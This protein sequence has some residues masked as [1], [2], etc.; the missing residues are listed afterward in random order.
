MTEEQFDALIQSLQKYA[1]QNPTNYKFRVALLAALGYGYIFFVFVLLCGIFW[2]ATK[3]LVFSIIIA[4]GMARSLSLS[5]PKPKG[6]EISRSELPALFALID[7]LTTALQAPQFHHIILDNQLNAAVL[8]VPRFGFLGWYRNYLFL[9]LPLMQSLS[10]AEFRAVVAHELG[11]LSGNHSRFVGWIYRLRNIWY[12]FGEGLQANGQGGS[13]LFGGFFK[14]YAPFFRAYSF[15]LARAHEY[16]ADRCAA[17]LAGTHNAAQ[18]LINL[19]IKSD[20]LRKYFWQNIFKKAIDRSSPPEATITN[21]VQQLR[22]EVSSED[23]AV[24]LDLALAEKTNNEDTHPCLFDRLSAFGYLPN[25]YQLPLPASVEKTAA[26]HFLGEALPNYIDRLDTEWQ[27]EISPIWKQLHEK[28]QLRS[29][30]LQN[31]ENLAQT[32]SLTIEQQRKRA[33]LTA[34]FKGNT[35]AIPLYREVLAQQPQHSIANFELG[36]LLI[37]EKDP[38]GIRHIEIA[39][40]QDPELLIPGSRLIFGFLKR[41]GKNEEAKIYL[42]KIEQNYYTWRQA[43]TE[44]KEVSYRDKFAHHNLP[45]TEAT[46]LA[47]QLATYPQIKEA[48]LVQKVV[49]HLPENPFYVLG[50]IRRYVSVK[51]ADY[52]SDTELID[53]VQNQLNFSGDVFAIVLNEYNRKLAQVL[54]K[55][56]GASIYR[57]SI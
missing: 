56:K 48:F 39:I 29:Q 16:E 31:L 9:G 17:E 4:V 34:E 45:D 40:A 11:H 28:A 41:Q 22:N 2:I 26:A 8:Q 47:Q 25:G 20:Y 1:R 43:A 23:A 14:W 19:D 53:L 21:L 27:N 55:I 36:H 10:P 44:R 49:T 38:V 12:Q 24:W 15:V 37:E 50:I 3:T 7:E 54:G 35:A 32:Q 13:I 52:K 33:Q 5:F 6:V 46:Q 51:V 42:E 57:R 18:A 30:N